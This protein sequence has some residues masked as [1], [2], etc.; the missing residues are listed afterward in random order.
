M[1]P[2]TTTARPRPAREPDTAPPPLP[3]RMAE[4]ERRLLAGLLS[5]APESLARQSR[6]CEL[7]V[8]LSDEMSAY[9]WSS[10]D[11]QHIYAAICRIA[12]AGDFPS[13]AAVQAELLRVSASLAA[14]LAGE[15]AQLSPGDAD[16]EHWARQCVELRYA[17]DAYTA[18]HRAIAALDAGQT[19]EDIAPHV[20]ELA[21]AASPAAPAEPE[22]VDPPA[23]REPFPVAALPPAVADYVRAVAAA[24]PCAPETI[25]LPL[26][27]ALASAI[28]NSRRIRLKAS[29]T[30]PS[31]IWACTVLPSGKLKSPAHE[32]AVQFLHTRQTQMFADYRRALRQ[33]EMDKAACDDA[34][35]RR[36][37][38][39][40]EELEP[41]PEP[42]VCRR[43]A[44]SD[45]TTEALAALLSEN[46][47]G[48]LLE[49]DE[50]S[51]WFGGYD[52]YAHGSSDVAA[53]LSMHRA[54]P[55]I[56]DRKTGQRV[57]YAPHAA[58]SIGGTIQPGALGRCL[59]PEYFDR[60]LPAR[61]LLSMPDSPRKR[62]SEAVVPPPVEKAMDDLFGALLALEAESL[63]DAQGDEHT[64]PVELPLSAGA[65]AAW[66]EFYDAHATEQEELVDDRESAAWSKLEAY[67]ARFALIFTLCRAPAATE[68]DAESMTDAIR[69]TR[70]FCAE[71]RRVY[72]ALAAAPE[73]R[74]E[75]ELVRLIR[76]RFGGLI[77][78]CDL[79]RGPRK[80]RSPGAAE[81]ALQRLVD[82]RLA[83][84]SWTP[85]DG[86][87][88]PSKVCVLR[89]GDGGDGDETPRHR[90]GMA[91]SSPSPV[92]P[93]ALAHA[94]TA[95][96]DSVPLA[97]EEDTAAAEASRIAEAAQLDAAVA[98]DGLFAGGTDL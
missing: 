67:A 72:A 63:L 35:K 2:T 81:E 9:R 21:A 37:G 16:V 24:L 29:W 74:Q 43:L 73:E 5:P 92:S 95:P 57:I 36:R 30:E 59:T 28:G 48:V 61:I 75:D 54:G 50:L 65:K 27:A 40:L 23:P 91:V 87:G 69:L 88:R 90:T 82:A 78:P 39:A 89:G 12:A 70:W 94:A 8:A 83:T 49:R 20:A 32:K 4:A 60:G 11:Y 15:L 53:Y 7:V 77:K 96:P 38:G 76:E 98:E 10:A 13:A 66:V 71:T 97:H 1:S 56:V 41:P 26:L 85:A 34:R 86:G 79:A 44:T 93:P 42:P 14:D 68:I 47:R 80:Y 33:Y 84:W 51:G 52:R 62:W 19:L 55:I 45:C 25:A 17:C 31:V 6:R 58:V 46:P 64:R 22:P 18:A 3:A